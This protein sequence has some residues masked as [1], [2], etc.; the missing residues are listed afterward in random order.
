MTPSDKL[1]KRLLYQ[2]QHRG[3]REMD[4]IL[5]GFADQNINSMSLQELEQ[6]EALL[7]FPDQHLYGWFFERAPLPESAPKNLIKAILAFIESR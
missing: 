3:M 7:A 5:G 1:R 4:L 6:F 2:S